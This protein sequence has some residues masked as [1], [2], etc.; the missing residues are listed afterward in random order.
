MAHDRRNNVNKW[1]KNLAMGSLSVAHFGVRRWYNEI[2]NYNFD[3][4]KYKKGIGH[5]TQ[6]IWKKTLKVGFGVIER[7]GN[8]FVV[9]KYSP[10]GNYIGD[11]KEN[12]LKQ[13]NTKKEMMDAAKKDFANFGPSGSKNINH[14][15][16][17]NTNQNFNCNIKKNAKKVDNSLS[18]Q[19]S[20]RIWTNYYYEDDLKQG[21]PDMKRRLYQ[22][23]ND[24][25]GLHG[26]PHLHVNNSLANEAQWYAHQLVKT[27]KFA[28]DSRNRAN[29]WGENLA[30]GSPS[31]A[32]LA[33]KWWYDEIKA[34]NFSKP[35]FKR[36]T[37]HFTQLV[38]KNTKQVGCGVAS[39]LTFVY[40]VCK[41]YPPGNNL[42]HFPDNV[43]EPIHK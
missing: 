35:G 5:F 15:T 6:L 11:F 31:I 8:I 42:N 22:Q 27:N 33:V 10:P 32:H 25:R 30:M 29:G 36:E 18:G 17:Y 39:N 37:G 16:N 9:C 4:P 3:N 26:V 24:Y 41:Y 1:G 38:W 2:K 40:V 43:V 13:Y 20:N 12:V 28:H 34:Y 7:N 14:N 23:T 19:I 21:F